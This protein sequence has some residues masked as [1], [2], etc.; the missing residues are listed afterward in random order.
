MKKS[1]SQE[2]I[3]A[4]LDL[5]ADITEVEEKP[6]QVNTYIINTP[7]GQVRLQSILPYDEFIKKLKGKK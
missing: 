3:K 4:N 1:I 2:Q 7:K 5:L 6:K